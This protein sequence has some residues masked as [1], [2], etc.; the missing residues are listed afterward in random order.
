[1]ELKSLCTAS[2]L[3]RF[4]VLIVPLWNWN[5]SELIFLN[6]IFSSNRTFMELKLRCKHK[7]SDWTFVLIVPLWNWNRRNQGAEV[8]QRKVLIVPLWNWNYLGAPHT[9]F[10][11]SSNRTFMELKS[12]CTIDN[13]TIPRVLIVPLWNWNKDFPLKDVTAESSNRTFMELK[14]RSSLKSIRRSPSSNRTFME[15]K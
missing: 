9:M 11:V 13:E 14:Y 1:M 5:I 2:S 4:W 6:I 15:L 12:P 8:H 10:V 3:V 7:Q